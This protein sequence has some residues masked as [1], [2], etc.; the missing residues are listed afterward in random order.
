MSRIEWLQT[1]IEA[2]NLVIQDGAD[3]HDAWQETIVADVTELRDR[4]QLE[5]SGPAG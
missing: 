5:L 1:A 2:C 4:L 3:P